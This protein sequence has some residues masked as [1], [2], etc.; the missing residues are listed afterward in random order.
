VSEALVP[1]WWIPAV[2][3]ERRAGAADGAGGSAPGPLVAVLCTGPCARVAAAGV[4]LALARAA[5][6]PSAIAGALAVGPGPGSAALPA[7][8]RTASAL[9][10]RELPAR[11]SGRLVWLADRRGAL[12]GDDDVAGRAAALGAEVARAAAA[13]GAPA[14]VAY[15]VARTAALDRL[16]A[17]HDAVV[18]VR[19]AEAP[20]GM[21][22]RAVA[23]V[24]ALGRPVGEL[25]LPGRLAGALAIVGTACPRE[26]VAAL[27]RLAGGSE[28]GDG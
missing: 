16:L 6:S 28:P 13:A 11:A 17:W 20:D 2:A 22:E 15:P 1:A 8:A 3:R 19:D 24:A 25:A 18:V 10:R 4:A 12:D 7:A 14:A 5:G 26:A 23:S 9:R 21:V 27:E